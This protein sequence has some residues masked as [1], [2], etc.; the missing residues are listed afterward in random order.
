MVDVKM[1]V[2]VDAEGPF[3]GCRGTLWWM[4]RD[5]LVDAEGPFGGCRGALGRGPLV[6]AEVN[7]GPFIYYIC[8]NCAKQ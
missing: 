2:E 8:L 1:D 7:A 6:D 3:G 4:Q 5:P